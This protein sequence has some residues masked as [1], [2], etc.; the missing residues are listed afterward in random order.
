ML[1]PMKP[2]RVHLQKDLSRHL[3]AGHPWVFADALRAAQIETGTVVDVVGSDG[4]FL[5]RGLYDA[6]SPIA[7]RAFS[8]DPAEAIDGALIQRRLAEA[9]A[10]RR[11]VIDAN[12][13]DAFRWC[14]GEGDFLP[15]IVV[16]LYERVAVV[17]FDGDAAR[18]LARE[19]TAAI[20]ELGRP[21]GV[22]HVYERS[23]GGKGQA[24]SGGEP[25]NPVEIR[26]HGV[27]LAVD[28]LHGQ[29][30]GSFLDQRENR[31]ALRRFSSGARVANLFS[32]TGGFSVHAALAGAISV[33]S[34]DSAAAALESARTNFILNGLSPDAHEFAARDVFEWLHEARSAQKKF[35]LVIVDPPSFAP[36]EKSVGKALSAYRDLF[37]SSLGVV[38]PGG[39][40][41]ACSCSSHVGM[42]ELVG[43]LR[44][45]AVKA[46]RTLRIHE[47]HGQPADHPTPPAFPE[48][49]YLKMIVARAR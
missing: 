46:L 29:K 39:I 24:L 19:V 22:T 41:A 9:L 10:A 8:L 12:T 3:R 7:V 42:D 36:S 33:A 43:A 5:A 2:P 31:V 27:R 30:T 13:T 4:K 23:R 47:L 25:P 1:P 11:G 32:Y 37:A 17:R 35:E 48:G 18:T 44:D 45:G 21:L 38:A 28:V 6:R 49:R 14:N 15:G 26:E 20:V 16:D 40:I 34:V